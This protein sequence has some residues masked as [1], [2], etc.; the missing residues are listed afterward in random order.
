[1]SKTTFSLLLIVGGAAIIYFFFL[2]RWEELQAVRADAA[3]AEE[4][5]DQLKALAAKRDE[6]ADTYNSV[7]A[8]LLEKANAMV[9][10]GPALAALLTDLEAIA[11]KNGMV[12]RSINF[13]QTDVKAK[14]GAAVQVNLKQ[15]VYTLPVTLQVL[16]TYSS[17][18]RFLTDLEL[19]QRIL[20]ASTI[21]FTSSEGQIYN[22][23]M[24]I[25]AY[26]Q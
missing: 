23:S 18:R 16:G 7:R 4:A 14:P 10:T 26:Y 19:N 6:L 21:N 12:L 11:A 9:T 15:G 20:D 17:F 25:K 2:S 22:V 1:M 3:A 5:I 13:G 8:S 24:Q